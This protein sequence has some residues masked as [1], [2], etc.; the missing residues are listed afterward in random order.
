MISAPT[1]SRGRNRKPQLGTGAELDEREHLGGLD[2]GLVFLAF[3]R[4][5]LALVGVPGKAVNPCGQLGFSRSLANASSVGASKQ[6][7]ARSSIL[8]ASEGV[9]TERFMAQ[10]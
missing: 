2:V 5:Q 4:S 3:A 10:G 6:S 9:G 7:A 8:S 1:S